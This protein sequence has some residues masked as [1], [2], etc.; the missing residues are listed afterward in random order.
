MKN[1]GLY[2]SLEAALSLALIMV[3]FLAPAQQTDNSQKEV[4]TQ[5]KMHDLLIVWAK[6]RDF[7]KQ[8][9]ASDFEFVFQNKNGTIEANENI[10]EVQKQLRPARNK[11]TETIN[12]VGDDLQFKQ[13]RLTVF[14]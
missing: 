11:I 13:I 2:F 7:S 6:Q 4:L 8:E 10:F 9:L 3:I 1:D 14:D 12:Y 5:Q